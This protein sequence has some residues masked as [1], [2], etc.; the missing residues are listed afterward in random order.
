MPQ[1]WDTLRSSRLDPC[2]RGPQIGQPTNQ[3]SVA[4]RKE[5]MSEEGQGRQGRQGGSERAGISRRPSGAKTITR[6]W[7]SQSRNAGS[8]I[9]RDADEFFTLLWV[10]ADVKDDFSWNTTICICLINRF[11]PR[12]IIVNLDFTLY[13]HTL[14]LLPMQF[15]VT[16]L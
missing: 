4:E 1:L 3:P 7:E 6:V 9:A 15:N 13:P 2:S 11:Y 12:R 16:C 10:W 14:N 5:H 8:T